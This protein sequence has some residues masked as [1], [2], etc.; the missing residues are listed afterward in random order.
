MNK[1]N[2]EP[3]INNLMENDTLEHVDSSTAEITYE[4]KKTQKG[5]SSQ[6]FPT[7]GFPPIIECIEDCDS[8]DY[9]KQRKYVSH[10]SSV[11]IK[12]IMDKRKEVTP[13]IS[14]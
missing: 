13:F 10:K 9:I 7:G 4:Q 1:N 2:Y 11:S 14:F 12:N 3:Y 5:G 8:N 6:H